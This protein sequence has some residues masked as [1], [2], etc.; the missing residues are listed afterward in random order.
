L[1]GSVLKTLTQDD[2]TVKQ[3][4]YVTKFMCILTL[5]LDGMNN[6]KRGS[7]TRI[8]TLKTLIVYIRRNEKSRKMNNLTKAE[9][10]SNSFKIFI[11]EN[12]FVNFV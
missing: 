9:W 2:V 3:M 12:V 1:K 5:L 10:R 11:N 4:L 8:L 7:N 6:C